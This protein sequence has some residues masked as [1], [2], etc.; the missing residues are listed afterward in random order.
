[1]SEKNTIETDNGF[2]SIVAR[3]VRQYPEGHITEIEVGWP[4]RSAIRAPVAGLDTPRV[5]FEGSYQELTQFEHAFHRVRRAA[6]ESE[7][8][9]PAGKWPGGMNGPVDECKGVA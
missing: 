4:C 6:K 7:S 9:R 1:M 3:M 8:I 5:V 2:E